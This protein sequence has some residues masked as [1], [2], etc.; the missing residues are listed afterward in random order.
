M[1]NKL[2]NII[3]AFSLCL[4]CFSASASDTKKNEKPGIQH[5]SATT[6]EATVKAVDYKKRIVTLEGPEGKTVEIEVPEPAENLPQVHVGDIVTADYIESVTIQ[7]YAPHNA[8][9]GSA[10]VS[11]SA[12]S[13]TG[14]KPA[15]VVISGISIL[16]TIEAIDSDKQM[17]TLKGENG[18]SKTVKVRNP[19]NLKNISVGDKVQI[20]YTQAIGLK[21][22][23]KPGKK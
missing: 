14:Q 22:T 3:I 9:S 18:K 13:E 15:A 1:P 21:V 4:T 20:T 17:V 10:A 12:K 11:S 2:I 6:I 8:P 7:A 23:A 16:T 19:D 5:I